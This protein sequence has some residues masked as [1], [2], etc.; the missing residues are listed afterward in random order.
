MRHDRAT[1]TRQLLVKLIISESFCHHLNIQYYIKLNEVNFKVRSPINL[2]NFNS[3]VHNL[4]H[5][6][7]ANI[8]NKYIIQ[9]IIINFI[10]V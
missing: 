2:H 4:L 8:Y 3:N 1:L 7:V 10:L 6:H 9:T 5:G